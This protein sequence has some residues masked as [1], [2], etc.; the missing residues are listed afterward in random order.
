MAGQSVTVTAFVAMFASLFITQVIGA[1][2]RR[3]WSFSSACSDALSCLLVSFASFTLLLL[4]RACLG[5]GLGG[6]LGDV[7]LAHHATGADAH[8]ARKPSPLSL[9][10]SPSRW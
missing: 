9:A 7:G 5:L 6:F 2:D 10:Q 8:R 1:I 4:G 3:R